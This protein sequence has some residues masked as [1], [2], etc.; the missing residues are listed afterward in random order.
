[1]RAVDLDVLRWGWVRWPPTVAARQ[2]SW[3]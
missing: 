1:M 2:M 3:Q